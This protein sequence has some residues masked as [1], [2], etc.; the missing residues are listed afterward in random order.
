MDC[1]F[2]QAISK[3]DIPRGCGVSSDA[4]A[5]NAIP[6]FGMA[7]WTNASGWLQDAPISARPH[8]SLYVNSHLLRTMLRML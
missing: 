4:R 8:I 1:H 3:F 7:S 2:P 5:E 6:I